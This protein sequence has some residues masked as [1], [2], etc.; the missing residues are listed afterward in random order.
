MA[1]DRRL[2]LALAEEEMIAEFVASIRPVRAPLE[3]VVRKYRC[4]DCGHRHVDGVD[5]TLDEP[6]VKGMVIGYWCCDE[7][8]ADFWDNVRVTDRDHR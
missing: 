2:M 7:C 1:A 8:G 3:S 5:V 4:A 6:T